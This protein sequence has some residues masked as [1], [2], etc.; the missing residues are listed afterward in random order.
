MVSKQFPVARV[1][2]QL[3]FD[4]SC[5]RVIGPVITLAQEINL[6]GLFK[7]AP[8]T[9]DSVVN[10][11]KVTPLVSE[12]F[13]AVLAAFGLLE[14]QKDEWFRLTEIAKT[15]MLPESPFFY[16]GFC[17]PQEWY[18]DLLR[19]KVLSGGQPPMP[20]A[21]GMKQHRVEV[22]RSFIERMHMMTLPAAAS[23]AKQPIFG[24]ISHLLDVGGGSG[25]LAIAIA[26][27]NPQI[28][29]TIL[30][31]EPVC[32][33]ARENIEKYGLQERVTT[34]SK[35][36]FED[37]WEE[38]TDGILFGNIFHDWDLESCY[39][40]AKRAFDALKPGGS[41]L[42]HE[43]PL[44]ETKDGPLTVACLS[45]ILL[46]YENG[47]QYTLHEL[48]EIISSVG[49]IDFKSTPTYVYYHLITASK[50]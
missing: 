14:R 34:V 29:C 13:I 31:L 48:E 42:M 1:D 3:L 41:I 20:L 33:I 35:D 47:K 43:M 40:L 8:Q 27:F 37:S 16:T 19:M 45:A 17:P 2:E 28:R 9:I 15:Y 32:Q 26:A 25:S 36:M 23:L 6:F 30:D 49:F 46:M 24:Q 39:L 22:V 10:S 18:L 7:Q 11:L 44:N 50:P 4:L 12:A 21:V 5:S 38:E